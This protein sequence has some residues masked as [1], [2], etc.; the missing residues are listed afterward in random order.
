[1]EK[2][3]FKKNL[4]WLQ[5]NNKN[6]YEKIKSITIKDTYIIKNNADCDIA[7][8]NVNGIKYPLYSLYNYERQISTW[9]GQFDC[10]TDLY[11]IY[12]LGLGH[13]VN[14]LLNAD[15]DIPLFIIEPDYEVFYYFLHYY[16]INILGKN[17]IEFFIGQ[18]IDD[19]LLFFKY[20]IEKYYINRFR[21]IP[22][23]GYYYIYKDLINELRERMKDALNEIIVNVNSTLHSGKNWMNNRVR[24]L[25]RQ[26][27]ESVPIEKLT[28][29]FKNIPAVMVSSGPSLEEDI[30]YIKSL[31]D[32]ALIVAV[33]TG[34]SVLESNG[35]RAHVV[36]ALC[37]NAYELEIF[38]N[39][40]VNKDIFLLYSSF[41]YPEVPGVFRKEKLFFPLSSFDGYVYNQ[42]NQ[43]PMMIKRGFS[44]AVSALD[45]IAQL[46]C[47]P[48]FLSGQDFCYSLE[49]NSAKGAAFYQHDIKQNPDFS[50]YMKAKNKKGQEVYTKAAFW[51]M[52]T[53]MEQ[54]VTKHSNTT[55]FN[56]SQNGLPI[57]GTKDVILSEVIPHYFKRRY[58][59]PE[60]IK[61]IYDEY[62]ELPKST[63]I[64]AISETIKNEVLKIMALIFE[65]VG[66][67]E[68]VFSSDLMKSPVAYGKVVEYEKQLEQYP[69]YMKV[70]RTEYQIIYYL[71]QQIN[72]NGIDELPADLRS[73]VTEL[74]KK[75]RF[76]GGIYDLCLTIKHV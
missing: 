68:E 6:L 28:G 13:E 74:E 61:R 14:S 21:V 37:D 58:K 23:T 12:G 34:L 42:L 8:K 73:I 5:K 65:I 2:D 25:A 66:T 51:A 70:L 75:R 22:Q 27:S 16:D 44:I 17:K 3:I 72:I 31:Y 48:I 18:S 47:N 15:I 63:S 20:I 30:E 10:S 71:F 24:N 57:R 64:L 53:A 56:C 32:C 33:G 4:R 46:G 39:I 29:Q 45:I 49:Q 60:K 38:K 76:Y 40:E 26:L 54:V 9:L 50:H 7:V 55:I 36:G 43:K 1:M 19:C 59:L 11:I 67:I 35:V 41:V 62:Q 52:K 69:F